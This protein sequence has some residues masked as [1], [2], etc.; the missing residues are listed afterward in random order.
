[1]HVSRK[2]DYAVRSLAYLAA[3]PARRIL[4]AE[5]A[6]E[7][8][9]PQAFLS[10]IMK[11]LVSGELVSSQPGPG[12]GYRLARGADEISFRDILELV[13]GPW[14]LVPC[15][16]EAEGACILI[17]NCSQVTVWD[18]IRAEMLEVLSK[19]RLADVRHDPRIIEAV[20]LIQLDSH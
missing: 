4:L 19:Y 5:I 7:V 11:E 18:R 17:A 1:M 20:T 14:N 2:A 10:K 15:Q 16:D 9:V 3:D 12:G 13:E 8:S 6:R